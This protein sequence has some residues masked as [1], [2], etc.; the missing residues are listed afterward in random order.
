MKTNYQQLSAA[1]TAAIT[2]ADSNSARPGPSPRPSSMKRRFQTLFQT[3]AAVGILC[4][5]GR[6][7]AQPLYL[8]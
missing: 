1:S 3:L 5:A 7:D 4:A 6:M 8:K 2:P